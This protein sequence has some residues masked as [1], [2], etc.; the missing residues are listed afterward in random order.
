M[1]YDNIKNLSQYAFLGKNFAKAAEFAVENDL[2]AMQ[3]GHYEID[4]E[5]LFINVLDRELTQM[6]TTWEVHGRYADIQLL[7]E[8][9][10]SIGICPISHLAEKPV[11]DEEKDCTFFEDLDG[12]LME[13]SPG[14]FIIALPQDIHKPNCPG[15]KSS[16][17]K[18]MV[19]KVLLDE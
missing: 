5:N 19:F 13:L 9:S 4:G 18:K 15:S 14:E 16:R 7:L 17:S 3:T 12:S 10:E 1:I 8:G 2:A 6:P 11:I